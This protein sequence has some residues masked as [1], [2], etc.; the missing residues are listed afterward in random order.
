MVDPFGN[1]SYTAQAFAASEDALRSLYYSMLA[2]RYVQAAA[3]RQIFIPSD[4][5]Q[6]RTEFW[7]KP[8]GVLFQVWNGICSFARRSRNK[9]I[10]RRALARCVCAPTSACGCTYVYAKFIREMKD[11]CSPVCNWVNGVQA[12][13]LCALQLLTVLQYTSLDGYA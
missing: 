2:K 4:R 3:P 6:A 10:R 7:R 13:I 9:R 5:F 11:L 12:G 8:D 1:R